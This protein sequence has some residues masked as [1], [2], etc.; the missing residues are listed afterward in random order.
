MITSNGKYT[1]E[2]Q[3]QIATA[4]DTFKKLAQIISNRNITTTTKM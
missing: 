1:S 3:R 4:K 2:V